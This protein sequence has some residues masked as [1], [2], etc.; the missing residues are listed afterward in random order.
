MR[1]IFDHF[2]PALLAEVDVDVRQADA[3]GI[4]EALEQEVVLQRIKLGDAERIGYQTASSGPRPG[5]T[6]MP[7]RLA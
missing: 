4:E 6:G 1:D 2:I 5:P 7:W 3:L